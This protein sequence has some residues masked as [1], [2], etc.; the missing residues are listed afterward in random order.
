MPFGVWGT[1]AD[2]GA[3]QHEFE[4]VIL[5]FWEVCRQS[6]RVNDAIGKSLP[7]IARRNRNARIGAKGGQGG[8]KSG[9]SDT[10]M[11]TLR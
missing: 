11:T 4:C 7:H 1:H 2:N 3:N 10:L 6:V 5:Q 9:A 8:E